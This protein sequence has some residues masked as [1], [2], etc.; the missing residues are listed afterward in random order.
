MGA[1]KEPSQPLPPPDD[2]C[3][4]SSPSAVLRW[5]GDAV[6]RTNVHDI[7]RRHVAG[8]TR[9]MDVAGQCRRAPDRVE[10]VPSRNYRRATAGMYTCASPRVRLLTPD[11]L[12]GL[13]I[14][15]ENRCLAVRF[16]VSGPHEGLPVVRDAQCGHNEAGDPV[17]NCGSCSHVG[18][19]HQQCQRSELPRCIVTRRI[20][21]PGRFSIQPCLTA[22]RH[23][24]SLGTERTLSKSAKGCQASQIAPFPAVRPETACKWTICP[25]VMW[26]EGRPRGYGTDSGV[27]LS[28]ALAERPSSRS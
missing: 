12:S 24:Q 9:R 6:Q 15:G 2:A 17:W 11:S 27:T 5:S 28:P 14:C 16:K 1:P 19:A 3:Q 4:L 10:A 18:P 22:P 23:N 7:A 26:G 21:T 8:R 13:A 20:F 25:S